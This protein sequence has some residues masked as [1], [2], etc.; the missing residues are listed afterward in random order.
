[1][2]TSHSK[3]DGAR[4]VCNDE[5]EE[6]LIVKLI[7][8]GRN[9]NIGDFTEFLTTGQFSDLILKCDDGQFV[10]CH[11]LLLASR[12]V[13]FK[14]FASSRS[15]LVSEITFRRCVKIEHLQ[16][17]V[18]LAYQC[19]INGEQHEI[20]STLWKLIKIFGI[21]VSA[22][23][24]SKNPQNGHTE[25]EHE[26]EN[27]TPD[28]QVNDPEAQERGAAKFER[29][30]KEFRCEAKR[31]IKK[32]KVNKENS[33]RANV[34][35]D[36]SVIL[37]SDEE[38]RGADEGRP[39]S[40]CSSDLSSLSGSTS[41]LSQKNGPEEEEMP[42]K[43]EKTIQRPQIRIKDYAKL[44][45]GAPQLEDGLVKN[46]G[47]AGQVNHIENSAIAGVRRGNKIGKQDKVLHN[48][49]HFVIIRLLT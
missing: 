35:A 31:R 17:L 24:Y 45:N 34:L 47:V 2:T 49:I 4:K 20:T 41:D 11:R 10:E 3:D 16:A 40:S 13:N 5:D 21:R 8:N 6:I 28:H 30:V 25:L 43:V 36:S 14:Y 44:Q 19:Q 33:N 22:K 32:E 37:I 26:L 48:P 29:V 12:A 38:Q 42:R 18:Q 9:H 7:G 39:T 23:C 27:D 46:N 1:M 15:F